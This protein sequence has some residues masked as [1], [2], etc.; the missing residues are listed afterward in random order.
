MTPQP[1]TLS[2]LVETG[3]E[4]PSF[5]IHERRADGWVRLPGTAGEGDR[6]LAWTPPCA[7][8]A[9]PARLE[10]TLWSDWF[11]HGDTSPLYFRSE[12]PH[13]LRWSPRTPRRP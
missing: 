5:V 6:G 3:Y 1:L 13:E 10:A 8:P 7:L 2:A 4:E 11:L 12:G 9:S